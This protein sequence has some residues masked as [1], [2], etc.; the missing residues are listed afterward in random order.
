MGK[1]RQRMT[2]F[3]QK[4]P[5]IPLKTKKANETIINLDFSQVKALIPVIE[6]FLHS[7][8]AAT[9]TTTTAPM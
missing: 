9:T 2:A 5:S 4:L 8:P 6:V 7:T 3:H 1:N